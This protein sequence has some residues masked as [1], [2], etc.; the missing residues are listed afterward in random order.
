MW[1]LQS[2]GTPTA[3]ELEAIVRRLWTGEPRWSRAERT[4]LLTELVA[5]GLALERVILRDETRTPRPG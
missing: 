1:R 5:V 4:T 2:I 3:R